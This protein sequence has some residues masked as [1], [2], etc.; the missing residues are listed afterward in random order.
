MLVLDG[1][2]W[3]QLQ[4]SIGADMPTLAAFEGGPITTVA[5]ST[6]A[7]ALT[8]DHDR[9]HA[10]RARPRRLPD[11]TSAA[12]SS[13]CCAGR[14]RPATPAA[15]T[16]RA[17]CKPF[18]PFM[19]EPVPWSSPRPT[20]SGTAFTEA[21]LR[22]GR[23]RS[24]GGTRRAWRST[25]GDLLRAG[26]PLIY[27]YYDGIDKIAH[28]RGF[29]RVLRGRAA[30][31]RRHR[32]AGPRAE[33]VDG[34]ALLVTADHGQV[35][36]GPDDRRPRRRGIE[37]DPQPVRRGPVPL[38]ARPARRRGRPARRGRV[39]AHGDVAWVMSRQEII[40]G[41]WFGPVVSPPDRGSLRRRRADATRSRSASSIRR[42]RAVSAGV[43]TR[44][45]HI[46]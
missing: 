10:R 32:R 1:L 20:S 36:V 42:Q 4:S 5:P 34:A 29:G 38:A 43:S 7:T 2:G 9:P 26:E 8:L 6:T 15:S 39:A 3:E 12:R 33:L 24:A 18:A 30:L 31:R 46:C 25:V 40:E 35:D 22:G 44:V 11:A 17:G 45:T 37:A 19:G 28:E 16:S 41:G 23:A 14:R 21:H 13:T 27:A